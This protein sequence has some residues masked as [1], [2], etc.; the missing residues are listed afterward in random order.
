MKSK[1]LVAV[2]LLT[3]GL[4]LGSTASVFADTTPA[5]SPKASNAEQQAKL[6]AYQAALAQ[7][8]IAMTQYR[9]ALLVNDINYRAAMT[10]YWSD[11]NTTINNYQT[12]W[13][14]TLATFQAANLAFQTKLDAIQAIR[15]T[16][17]VSA[18]TTFLAAIASTPTSAALDAALTAHWN[19]V[20]LA[21]ANFKVAVTALGAGPVRPT[22][23]AAPVRPAAPVKPVD[24][25]KPEAPKKNG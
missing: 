6:A 13:Q 22:K 10:K 2:A 19:A 20:Q 3:S 17:V 23:P 18:D 12:S 25:V 11:W 21:N 1:K 7:Y 16:A 4:F 14:N 8:K 5:P 15:Q 24:P 9:V